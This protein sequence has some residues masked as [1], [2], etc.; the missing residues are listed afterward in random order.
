MS[1]LKALKN[2]RVLKQ[3]KIELEIGSYKNKQKNSVAEKAIREL[4]EEMVKVS[5]QGGKISETQL[6]K[7]TMNLNFRIRHT[8]HSARELWVKRDQNIGKKI[9]DLQYKM[10]VDSHDSSAQYESKNA[11]KVILPELR[12]KYS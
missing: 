12:T 10:R 2:D 1:S 6:A 5:P 11:T 4:R 7:A 8:G 3:E 9:S